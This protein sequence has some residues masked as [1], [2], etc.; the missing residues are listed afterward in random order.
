[1]FGLLR[2]QRRLVSLEDRRDYASAYCNLC[3]TLSWRYGLTARVLVVHDVA[4]ADW[5][6]AGAASV[7]RT[8]P[9]CNCLKGG[10]RSVA[11]PVRPPERQQFL[12]AV[13]AYAIG[14]KLADDVADGGGIKARMGYA[15]YKGTFARARA[16][17]AA[18]DFDLAA[19]EETLEAQ[20]AVER[21]R[22]TDLDRA[23]APSGAAFALVAGRL[24]QDTGGV[25][26]AA[27]RRLGDCIGR[28]VLLA[29]A[30]HDFPHD[31]ASD[32]YNP[33]RI[34]DSP[35]ETLDPARRRQAA[36]A[37]R[38]LLE[39][40]CAVCA[41]MGPRVAARWRAAAA[42]LA[43]EASITPEPSGP[44][45]HPDAPPGEKR[46]RRRRRR[47]I[48]DD[49]EEEE[50]VPRFSPSACCDIE[51]DCRFYVCCESLACLGNFVDCCS[52]LEL[53]S[54]C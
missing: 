1:M 8:F 25:E 41:S 16:D 20:R 44:G 24:A 40:A 11:A 33:L 38:S 3:A 52:C 28:A 34:T 31:V 42:T 39:E 15:F 13:S 27:A 46:P 37:V 19:F 2:P 45:S 50:H 12:A 49:K 5:L 9:I 10:V 26:P 47:A 18:A 51:P 43:L 7:Q 53:A 22:E 4:A 29:D 23:T 48:A 32:C 30:C 54:C 35:K 14:V 21:R 17:L 36:D 6:L